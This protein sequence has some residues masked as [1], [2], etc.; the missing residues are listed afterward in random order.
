MTFVGAASRLA[1]AVDAAFDA[2][3]PIARATPGYA[4]RSAQRA[5]ARAVAEAIDRREPLV[6]EA[7]TGVGKTW[8]YLVPALLSGTRVLISTGTKTLQDQLFRRDL[9][10]IRQALASGATVAL[11]KG[12]GN[13]VC[14]HHL[15]RNLAEGHFERREDIAVLR[16][17]ERFAAI[18]NTGDRSEAPGIAEDAPAWALATSTRENCLGQDCADFADCFV[19]RA[20]QAAQAADVVVVNHHLFCADLSLRDEGITDLLPSVHTVVLDEA[21]QL[22]QVATGFLGCSVSS[23]QLVDFARDLHRAGREEALDA[24]DWGGL[25]AVIEQAVRELRL[26]AGRPGRIDARQA[27][28]NRALH[29][30]IEQLLRVLPQQALERF[31][32]RGRE[33]ARLHAR[34]DELVARLRQWQHGV[35]P[36]AAGQAGDNGESAGQAG[37]LGQSEAVGG[38]VADEAEAIH[39]VEVHAGGVALQITPLSVA[40]TLRRHRQANACAWICTS[41]TLSLAGSFDHF[42]RSAG[43]EDARTL[44]CESPFDYERHAL[45]YVPQECGDPASAGYAERVADAAWPLIIANGGRAFVLCTSLRMVEHQAALL[46]ERIALSD[47]GIELLVQGRASR[48]A[49]IERFR[50]SPRPLLVGSASFWEGVD[51]VGERLSLVVIDKL[52]FAAPDDP[53]LAARIDA[54]RRAGRDPFREMQLPA[55]ALSLKQGAGRLIRSET[56]RGVLMICDE[57]LVTRSYGRRLVASLPAFRRTR[58]AGE[59]V[60]FCQAINA[61]V[62]TSDDRLP[63]A[64]S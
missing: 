6:V 38:Q 61:T 49:L 41:A 60:A 42:T 3:G 2:D 45:L 13:Y 35:W 39:W 44:R 47:S 63:E 16:R 58:E 40:A 34:V 11:L 26:A 56:D 57:R 14:R 31:A 59:A 53:I 20:R 36:S 9:P 27:R 52:P 51:V 1:E 48:S 17:I 29:E 33:L 55:A 22:P 5:M 4:L 43:L 21:H 28:V 32:E 64:L 54:A 37:T 8:A 7:G 30:A 15:R 46:T 18:S 23:R 62:A 24:A 25:S 19:F 50:S 12:R 10:R